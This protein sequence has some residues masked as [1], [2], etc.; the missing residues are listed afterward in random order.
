MRGLLDDDRLWSFACC[1]THGDL[2]PD[3]VLVDPGGDL[4]GVLDWEEASV[5]DPALDFAWWLDAMPEQGER[6]LAA[7]GGAPDGSFRERAHALF[8]IM[9]WY[10][11]EHGLRSEDRRFVER[12]LQ[13][14]RARLP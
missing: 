4:V 2:G 12:G 5:G 1:L 6:A 10:E 14:T 9:P 8:A 3:H 7:Y 13:G 11:V